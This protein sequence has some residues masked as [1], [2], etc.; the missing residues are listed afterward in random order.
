MILGSA[1]KRLSETKTAEQ[2]FLNEKVVNC[3]YQA[4]ENEND[5]EQTEF[6]E[7]ENE[8]EKDENVEYEE[9]GH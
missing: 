4:I 8:F 6:I 5:P 9:D 2:A 1:L 3:V 7:Y